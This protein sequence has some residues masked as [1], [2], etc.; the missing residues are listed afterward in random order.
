VAEQKAKILGAVDSSLGGEYLYFFC[1]F[2]YPCCVVKRSESQWKSQFEAFWSMKTS[3]FFFGK[4][5]GAFLE[6][7]RTCFPEKMPVN[8]LKIK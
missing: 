8:F 7:F 3:W 2:L 6:K 4:D 5:S 1:A